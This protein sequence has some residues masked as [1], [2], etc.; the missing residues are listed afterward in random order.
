MLLETRL[1]A[2]APLYVDCET[3]GGF[4]KGGGMGGFDPDEVVANVV[5]TATGL[6]VALAASATGAA[7]ARPVPANIELEFGLR[8]DS[9]AVISVAQ[10]PAAGQFKVKVRWGG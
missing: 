7:E 2:N 8:V 5:A 9:N 1:N 10:N 6:A 4:D 3:V